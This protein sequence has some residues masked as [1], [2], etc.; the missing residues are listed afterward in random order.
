MADCSL[1]KLEGDLDCDGSARPCSYVSWVLV[2]TQC[3]LCRAIKSKNRSV[4]MTRQILSRWTPML[5]RRCFTST[6]ACSSAIS[7]PGFGLFDLGMIYFQMDVEREALSGAFNVGN[8]HASQTIAGCCTHS[9]VDCALLLYYRLSVQSCAI[10][11]GRFRREI[12][13]L[14]FTPSSASFTLATRPV[15]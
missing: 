13:A 15:Q 8:E 14:A 2:R 9:S 1:Q 7:R 10:G 12:H 5:S 11:V 4:R 3:V 6:I